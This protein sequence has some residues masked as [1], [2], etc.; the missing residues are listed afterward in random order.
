M[1]CSA[2]RVDEYV[3]GLYA[4]IAELE[5]VLNKL[6]QHLDFGESVQSGECDGINFIDADGVNAAFKQA[7]DLITQSGGEA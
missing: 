3:D 6:D 5:G 2:D 1:I 4:R 7:H